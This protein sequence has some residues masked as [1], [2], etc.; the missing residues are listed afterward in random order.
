MSVGF[1]F[2]VGDFLAA[3]ELVGTVI[4]ALRESSHARDAFRSLIDELYTLQT[5]LLYVKRLDPGNGNRVEK[6]ALFNTA[7]QCQ[8]T[9]DS[10]YRRIQK[11]QPHLQ[12]DGTGSRIKD[13]W[14][15]IKWAVCKKDDLD[16][17]RTE[18]RGHTTSLQ[19]L[20]LSIQMAST[21]IQGREQ[22]SQ[23]DGLAHRIQNF[24]S[25]AGHSEYRH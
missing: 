1:G 9:I 21:T 8:L 10:F 20:M 15:K 5:A 23:N 2:S 6:I 7:T 17:F 16:T 12:Q 19:V 4:D 25:Q 13:G 18:I 3:L 14:A 22:K 24:S 11:Y